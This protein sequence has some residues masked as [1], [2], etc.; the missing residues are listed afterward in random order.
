MN[1]KKY[2]NEIK[3]IC[4]EKQLI[5]IENRIKN[6]C[7]K[8]RH[9]GENGTY[10]VKSVYFDDY[11]D[12]CYYENIDGV[13]ER[14]KMRIRT[15]N[16]DMSHISLECKSKKNGKNH[17][18]SC[19]LT[20]E[21]C[22]AILN[23]NYILKEEDPPVLRKLMLQASTRMMRP[24]V[25]VQYNR[26]PYTYQAGN[27][28]ITFDRNISAGGD[29]LK[30]GDEEL[31]VQPVMPSGYHILEVKYDEFLPDFIRSEMQIE[32]LQHTAFSKYAICRRTI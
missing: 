5:T 31:H 13:N 19:R 20:S 26:T 24:K 10:T 17:K 23:G 9:A 30:F 4:M 14:E 16:N 21:Q 15:Y 25:I 29:V 12:S 18:T 22:E 3:Y 28:R 2:R 11:Y 7:M 32:G 6:I 27:V 8:D 1:D